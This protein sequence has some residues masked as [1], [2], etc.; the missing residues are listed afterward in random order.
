MKENFEGP[1]IRVVRL[2]ELYKDYIKTNIASSIS[3][4]AFDMYSKDQ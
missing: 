4:P 1:L 3:K 2:T